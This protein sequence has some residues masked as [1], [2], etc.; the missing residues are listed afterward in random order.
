MAAAG[1]VWELGPI[2]SSTDVSAAPTAHWL[3]KWILVCSQYTPR[4]YRALVCT[5]RKVLK[6]PTETLPYYFPPVKDFLKCFMGRD[7]LLSKSVETV[8]EGN[9]KSQ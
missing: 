4:V 6:P 3:G 2:S 7:P 9:A 1:L 5:L 8:A